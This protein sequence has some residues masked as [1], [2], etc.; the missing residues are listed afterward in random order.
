MSEKHKFFGEGDDILPASFG[1][2]LFSVFIFGVVVVPSICIF[3]SS[4]NGFLPVEMEI[5]KENGN[6]RSIKFDF[7]GEIF[8]EDIT[9]TSSEIATFD[10]Q[11]VLMGDIQY[12]SFNNSNRIVSLYLFLGARVIKE[13]II[14]HPNVSRKISE[15]VINSKKDQYK[16]TTY[17]RTHKLLIFLS[18]IFIWCVVFLLIHNGPYYYK[19]HKNK[20]KSIRKSMLQIMEDKYAGK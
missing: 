3:Q 7:F 6:N 20:P 10:G 18:T 8:V 16:I 12:R 5:I 17:I 14:E 11:S 2:L 15:N 19:K 4:L 9:L 1:I 13:I